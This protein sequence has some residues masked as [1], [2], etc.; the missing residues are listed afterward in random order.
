M[1]SST[2]SE[3]EITQTPTADDLIRSVMT[4]QKRVT[5]RNALP[6][7]EPAEP[8]PSDAEKALGAKRKTTL[9]SRKRLSVEGAMARVRSYRPKRSHILLAVLALIMYFRPF[10]IPVLILINLLV[11]LI[12]YLSLGPDR[13]HEH[14]AAAWGWLVR[15]RPKRAEKLRGM[16]D[17]FALRFDAFLDRLPDRWAEKLA[18]PDFS[19]S[20]QAQSKLEDRPDPFDR[21]QKTPEV[22]RG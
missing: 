6:E 16:A 19:Q 17:R 18:L 22:Y 11:G 10:L 20:A 12:I 2:P 1:P 14:L 4:E 21:L 13:A 3:R 9:K 7:L 15:N 5:S 8:S